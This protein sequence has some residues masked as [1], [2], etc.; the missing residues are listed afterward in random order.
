LLTDA[1]RRAFRLLGWHPGPEITLVVIAAVADVSPTEG[2]QLLREL[3]SH[4]LVDQL[5]V[6][7]VPGGPRYRMHDLVRLYARERADAEEPLLAEAAAVDRL[8]GSYLAITRAADRLLRPYV[9]GDSDQST[10]G[11]VVAFADESKARTWLTS[12]RHNLLACA[13]AMSPRTKAADLSSLLAGHFWD[14]GFWYDARY[15]Y[16]Q[17]LPSIGTALTG[18]VKW[19]RCVGRARPS[20]SSVNTA[21]PVSTTPRL[22]PSPG[23]S[24]TSAAK[25]TRCPGWARLSGASAS[26]A[27]PASITPRL[28]LSPGTSVT[29]AAKSTHYRGWVTSSGS[30]ATTT[31]PASTTPG[32]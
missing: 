14:F 10:A 11:T 30:S 5:S 8:A 1:Q 16:G 17:A 27:R 29:T 32:L 22:S 4:N 26:T 31:K 9:S 25:W 15:L 3:A 12:E 6:A 7:G 19:R 21:T 20:G 18:V 13:R 28:W 2:K 24:V 23:T